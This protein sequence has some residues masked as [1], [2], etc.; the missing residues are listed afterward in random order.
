MY[1]NLEPW[2]SQCSLTVIRVHNSFNA[3]NVDEVLG[4]LATLGKCPPHRVLCEHSFLRA[5]LPYIMST[6]NRVQIPLGRADFLASLQ[7]CQEGK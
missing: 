2:S 5:L 3:S 4:L 1:G 6:I 7:K